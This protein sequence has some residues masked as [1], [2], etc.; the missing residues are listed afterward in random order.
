MTIEY[1]ILNPTG[2]ITAL[3][4]DNGIDKKYYT[5]I[6]DII[7]KENNR[8]EQVGFIDFRKKTPY[9]CMAGGEFCGNATMSAAVLYSHIN[10]DNCA[11]TAIKVFGCKNEIS[12]KSQ[13]TD[14]AYYCKINLEKPKSIYNYN[15]DVNGK[16]FNL[17]VVEFEGISHIITENSVSKNDAEILLKTY[18]VKLNLSA[19]G[20][21]IFNSKTN[22]ITPIV[23]VKSCETLFY[24]N[25]CASGSCALCAYLTANSDSK[26]EIEI[27]QPGGVLKTISS[28]K[29]KYVELYE[30]VSIISHQFTEIT[31]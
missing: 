5:Q 15:F 7:M 6:S 1:Y 27:I 29:A 26:T 9:L 17:P 18:A 2:N 30:K 24:E 11:D 13:K 8:I 21:M 16:T 22:E 23:Y 12:V 19:L 28:S 20:I 14:D 4:I 3:V 31:V 25:S 10:C